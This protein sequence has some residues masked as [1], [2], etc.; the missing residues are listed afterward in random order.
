MKKLQFKLGGKEML[1]KEQMKKVAGAEAWQC[2][3]P[4]RCSVYVDGTT[5]HGYCGTD[6]GNCRCMTEYGNYTPTSYYSHCYE[7]VA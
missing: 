2:R 1:T 7:Q 3:S 6:W 5:Y 4:E